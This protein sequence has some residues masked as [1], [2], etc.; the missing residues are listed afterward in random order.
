VSSVGAVRRRDDALAWTRAIPTWAWL[1]GI[2][3]LSAV[4]RYGFARRTVS[5]WIMIDELVYSE[6]AKSLAEHGSFAIRDQAA[7]GAYGV[8]YPLLIAP[9]Y[10]LFD[11][12]PHVYAAA[13]AIN[14]IVISLAAVPVYLIARRL[15]RPGLALLAAALSLALPSLLYAGTL[16]TENAFYPLFLCAVLALVAALERPTAR[17]VVVLL[18]VIGIAFLTRAQAVVFVPAMLTAP[19]VLVAYGGRKLREFRLL[20]AIPAALGVFVL[21]AQLVRGRSPLDL[22]GAYRVTGEE[23]YDVTEVAR[24]LLYHVAELDL[25]LA[26]VPFA[27]LIVLAVIARRLEPRDR[28][29]VAASV[30]VIA[31]LLLQVAAFASR[32][33]LRVEE[34]NMFYVAPL[35]VIALLVWVERGAPRP[36]LTLGIAALAAVLPAL[37]PFGT[38]IRDSAVSDTFGLL[39]WWTV[40][41]WGIP[42]DRLWLV[43]LAA[44]VVA[45]LAFALTPVRWT[46]VLPALLLLFFTVTTQPVDARTREA[47][48]GALFQGITRPDRDW[49]DRSTRGEVAAIWTR[50]PGDEGALTILDNEFFSRNV[51]RVFRTVDVNVPGDLAQEKLRTDRRTGLLLDT[52]GRPVRAPY[53]LVDDSL[54]VRGRVVARDE[55]KG[56]RV[57]APAGPLGIAYAVDGTYAD[58]WSGPEATYRRFACSGGAVLATVESDPR[59]FDRPQRLVARSGAHTVTAT[60]PT[61]RSTMVRVPLERDGAG[62]CVVRFS[63]A[64]TA[65]PGNGDP[66]RLGTH[67]RSFVYRP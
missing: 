42:L 63:V 26:V 31:W 56:L 41:E 61:A 13:K 50:K 3:V 17:R 14:S 33:S 4:V 51:G 11:S 8:V 32:H 39:P 12:I 62:N 58:G 67:F 53:V 29:F 44:C 1:A 16:M 37:L 21:L 7:G 6:L 40:H 35:F 46:I 38:L 28:I 22:L 24:W 27:A 5:P 57:V 45:A 34:R 52:A 18:A 9:A 47:S 54:P 48:I 55:T 19:L 66:R 59:L 10:L 36:R 60:I 43:V 65:V 15:L 23:R 25:S 49:I 64:P 30:S 20:Y 2:V